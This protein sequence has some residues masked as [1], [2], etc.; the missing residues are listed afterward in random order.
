MK[1]IK[2]MDLILIIVCILTIGFV[3]DMIYLFCQYQNTPTQLIIC[4]FALVGGE[5]GIMGWIKNTK[6][7]LRERQERLEDY[8]RMKADQQN[9]Q[10]QT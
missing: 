9:N 5:C 8:E 3:L 1:K 7:H 2:T 10:N 4:W 6:E